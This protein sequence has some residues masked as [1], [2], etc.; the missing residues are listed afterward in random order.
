[1]FATPTTLWCEITTGTPSSRPTRKVSSIDCSTSSASFLMCV[2]YTPWNSASGRQ[3][4]ITSSAGA[5]IAG[6]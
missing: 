2:Q 3:T 1:M 5:A 4:S 6:S